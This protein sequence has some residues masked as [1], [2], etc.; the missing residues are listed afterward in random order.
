VAAEHVIA[1]D[2]GGA[3]A[4]ATRLPVRLEFESGGTGW[5]DTSILLPGR[6][7]T[8]VLTGARYDG[9]QLA[10]GELLARYPVA[11]LAVDE[12]TD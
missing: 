9:G 5:G 7:V 10:V 4:V 3:V 12:Q 1:F 11:L 8:D 6:P 2:R